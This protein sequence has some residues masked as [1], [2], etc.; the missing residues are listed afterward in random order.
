MRT[1]ASFLALATLSLLL[2]ACGGGGGSGG[3]ATVQG[4]VVLN[5]AVGQSVAGLTATCLTT[6]QSVTTGED[7]SFSFDVPTGETVLVKVV[8][9]SQ[10]PAGSGGFGCSNG[11]STGTVAS[12]GSGVALEPLAAGEVV[13]VEVELRDGTVVE[14]W[15]GG[16]GAGT[17]QAQLFADPA[18]EP[19][20]SGE[21]GT[22]RDG[23]CL[24]V[25]L[26]VAGVSTPGSLR[27]VLYAWGG[28]ATLGTLEVG[29]D[30]TGSLSAL[31]CDTDLV[32][33]VPT[34]DEINAQLPPEWQL[35]GSS[36]MV[37]IPELD[38]FF[39]AS[40]VLYDADGRAVFFGVLPGPGFEPAD[41]YDP[42]ALPSEPSAS[43]LEALANDL[44]AW[45]EQAFGNLLA[46]I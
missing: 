13:Y 31:A 40:V 27:A 15:I 20:A 23:N 43:D 11:G 21:I 44:A 36:E 37:A 24:S 14:C 9:A 26:S 42:A 4:K 46:G 18:L 5:N 7:G 29:L 2:A 33:D 3:S 28:E 25:E 39:G 1:R 17:G 41:G 6:G 34:L 30:G 35:P 45:L 16:E 32:R 10:A 38:P 19:E 12:D 8:D 22:T